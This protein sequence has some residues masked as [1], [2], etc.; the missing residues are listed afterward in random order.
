MKE[1]IDQE[2]TLI[3]VRERDSRLREGD[4]E[5]LLGF[6]ETIFLNPGLWIKN[7]DFKG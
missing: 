4:F 5:D 6:A 3:Q 2:L 7:E 1:A